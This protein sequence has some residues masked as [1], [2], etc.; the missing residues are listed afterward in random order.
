[1][2]IEFETWV[3]EIVVGNEGI[4]FE[5]DSDAV[6]AVGK[7]DVFSLDQ[8]AVYHRLVY[9]AAVQLIANRVHVATLLTAK[10]VAGTANLNRA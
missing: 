4:D 5:C 1:M 7:W 6:A 10:E 9:H 8:A 3:L 2:E